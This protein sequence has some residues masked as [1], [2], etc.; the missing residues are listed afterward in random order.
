M[1]W[2]Y[3]TGESKSVDFG[4][5][6]AVS[7][8]HNVTSLLEEIERGE[9]R[10]VDFMELQACIGGCVGGPLN[11]QNLFVGRVKLRQMVKKY[12]STTPFFQN[13]YLDK[14]YESGR[15]EYS[16]SIQPRPIMVLDEDMSKALVK[17]ERLDEITEDLP[18]LDCGACGS[19]SCRALAEDIVRGFAFNTNCV[20]KLR[21]RVK[22][23][24]EELLDLAQKLPPAMSGNPIKKENKED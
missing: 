15:F 23:L 9:L 1:V 24:A 20:I 11:I 4:T 13:E 2:G 17:M 5:G 19:P 14:I 8:I 16:E 22:M 21:G 18:G 7:G 12:S 3:V 10:D 6:L